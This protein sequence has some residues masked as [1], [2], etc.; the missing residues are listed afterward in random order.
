ME[1]ELFTA[2]ATI[3]AVSSAGLRAERSS[4]HSPVRPSVL[5]DLFK[6]LEES[7]L[8][9]QLQQMERFVLLESHFTS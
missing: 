5:S 6:L 9:L 7:K 3:T 2:G 4:F 8:F 1:V